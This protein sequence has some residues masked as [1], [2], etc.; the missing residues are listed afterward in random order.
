MWD[1]KK[2]SLWVLLVFSMSAGLGFFYW[3]ATTNYI[4]GSGIPFYALILFELPFL[5]LM[6]YVLLR[7]DSIHKEEN[8]LKTTKN[9]AF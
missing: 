3:W 5:I 8:A 7:W 2:W 4:D 9:T 6:I 1:L